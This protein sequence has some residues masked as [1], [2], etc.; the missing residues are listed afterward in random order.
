MNRPVPEGHITSPPHKV[1]IPRMAFPSNSLKRSLMPRV[2]SSLY[3]HLTQ[4]RYAAPQIHHGIECPI[5]DQTYNAMKV[6][7][8][9]VN[10]ILQRLPVVLD[11]ISENLS[12]IH[13]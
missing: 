7:T 13:I 4:A 3:L 10:S 2:P 8:Y 1:S 12:L 9:N 5:M 11:W 6:A